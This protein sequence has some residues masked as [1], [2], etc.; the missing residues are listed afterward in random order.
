M[1]SEQIENKSPSLSRLTHNSSSH[2]NEEVALLAARLA[3][4]KK[5][6]NPVVLDLRNVGAFSEFFTIVSVA[7]SRQAVAVAE[8]V[9]SF[10]KSQ[11]GLRPVAVDGIETGTWVLIDYGFLFI[12]IFQEDVRQKYQ[13]EQLW[14]KARMLPCMD[15]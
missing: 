1:M 7:N 14:S 5:A 9:V 10:F 3:L 12:H 4:E 13:L 11:M 2:S 6:T 8:D 15:A